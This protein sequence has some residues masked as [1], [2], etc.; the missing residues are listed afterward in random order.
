MR[1]LVMAL[2]S[3]VLV[4]VLL[5]PSSVSAETMKTTVSDRTGDLGMYDVF[6]GVAKHSGKAISAPSWGENAP[7]KKVG[8]L[9]M[10]SLSFG[11][12]DDGTYEYEVI[13][14]GDS[15]QAGDAL[16]HGIKLVAWL[17]WIDS[18]PWT[19]EDPAPSLFEIWVQYD[20]TSYAGVCRNT[21]T[22]DVTLVPFT[23]GA[24]SFQI[25]ISP[26]TIGNLAS[27]WWSAAT[28]ALTNY[29]TLGWMVDVN[30]V[31][32]VPGQVWFDMPWPPV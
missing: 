22:G 28:F 12:L 31:E 11:V 6:F 32:R 30:D 24:S 18:P 23:M 3:L 4:G 16:P 7:M 9:D 26:D 5:I 29:N 19:P 8:Y 10:V 1:R 21:A 27:F 20:G 13:V 2:V 15:P 17:L 14:A 25:Q